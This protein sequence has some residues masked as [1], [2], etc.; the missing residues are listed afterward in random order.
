[1]KV[2]VVLD[3]CS[4]IVEYHEVYPY[5]CANKEAVKKKVRELYEKA[6]KDAKIEKK[7]VDNDWTDGWTCTIEDDYACV[8]NE[9]DFREFIW[10][11][12]CEVIE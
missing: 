2:Y 11:K 3:D 1:M 4:E 12:E 5:V 9:G 6:K 7:A 10:V 8:D